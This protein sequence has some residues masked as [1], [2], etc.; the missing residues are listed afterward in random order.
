ML[1]LPQLREF[2]QPLELPRTLKDNY[3][4]KKRDGNRVAVSGANAIVVGLSR[5]AS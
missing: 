2:L 4:I 5:T 1:I 3:F